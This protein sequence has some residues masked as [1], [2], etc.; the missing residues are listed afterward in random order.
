MFTG[1]RYQ[2]LEDQQLEDLYKGKLDLKMHINEYLLVQDT[3]GKVIDKFRWTGENGFVKVKYK[4]I[5]NQ[6]FGKI[7][8]MNP[9]QECMLNLLQDQ[10]IVGKQIEGRYGVG[11]TFLSIC[12]ALNEIEKGKPYSRIV[13]MR[14]TQEVKDVPSIGALPGDLKSKILPFAMPLADILGDVSI[15]EQYIDDGRI[16]LDHIG[17][18]R[19]RSF[20]NTI[21]FLTESQNLSKAHMGLIVSRIGSDCCLLV[22][23]DCRQTDRNLFSQDSGMRAMAEKFKGNK[24]FGMVTLQKTVR[25]EFAALS[26]LLLEN[27]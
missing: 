19:G 4:P 10:S 5:D 7:K 25:S 11:K 27:D 15:L 22:D 14:S 18:L 9:E 3:E 24:L 6:Y 26:D 23:G 13:F 1:I 8:A 21:V 20:K 17:F 12:W 2:V 16:I